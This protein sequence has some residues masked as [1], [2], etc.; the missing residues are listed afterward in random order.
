MFLSIYIC[1]SHSINSQVLAWENVLSTYKKKMEWRC[2]NRSDSNLRIEVLQTSALATWLRF[3]INSMYFPLPLSDFSEEGYTS[4]Y[5]RRNAL[6]RIR[7]R[8]RA[9]VRAV[10]KYFLRIVI[11]KSSCPRTRKR[12]AC[13]SSLFFFIPY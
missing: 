6:V 1:H 10:R 2:R 9:A 12:I 7:R 11:N 13:Y 5:I 3:P 4:T 8:I